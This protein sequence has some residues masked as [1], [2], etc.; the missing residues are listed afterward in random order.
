V[1]FFFVTVEG[2]TTLLG[3]PLSLFLVAWTARETLAGSTNP[4]FRFF[5]VSSAVTLLIYAAWAIAYG[6]PFAEPCAVLGC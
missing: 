4:V 2:E 3:I 5:L 1:T 6:W